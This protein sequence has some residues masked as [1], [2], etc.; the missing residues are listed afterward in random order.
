MNG[1]PD[2]DEVITV[3]HSLSLQERHLICPKTITIAEGEVDMMMAVVH[4]DGVILQTQDIEGNQRYHIPWIRIDLCLTD[5]SW[6]GTERQTLIGF[7]K[8]N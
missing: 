2:R 1:I 4:L 5:H 3:R 6:S 7:I 8:T